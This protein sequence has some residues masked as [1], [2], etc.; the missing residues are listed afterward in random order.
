VGRRSFAGY[1]C[2]ESLSIGLFGECFRAK[3]KK[4]TEARVV[5]VDS[6]L[7]KRKRFASALARHGTKLSEL[8]HPHVVTTQTVGRGNDGSLVVIASPVA[9]P[10]ELGAL[11]ERAGGRIPRDI[12]LS[13]AMGA[14]RGLSHAHEHEVTHGGVHP[15]SIVV[16]GKGVSKLSD[17]GLARALASAAAA[18]EDSELLRGLRGYVAPELALG[19]EPDAASDVFAAG[20]L[21]SQLLW[22]QPTPPDPE[23]SPL[24]DV[25]RRAINTDRDK[26]FSSASEL[27]GALRRAISD[28]NLEVAVASKVGAYTQKV[29]LGREDTGLLDAETEDLLN[30]LGL[31]AGQPAGPRQSTALEEV[32]AG[33]GEFEGLEDED[34][35][36][37]LTRPVPPTAQPVAPR[38]IAPRAATPAPVAP[39][40]ATPAPVAPRAAAPRPVAPRAATPRPVAPRPVA[41]RPI[42][43]RVAGTEDITNVADPDDITDVAD[44]DDITNV[45]D[46]EDIISVASPEDVIPRAATPRPV[47][48][49]PH[50]SPGELL[51]AQDPKDDYDDDDDACTAVQTP[52]PVEAVDPVEAL[53]QANTPK[54]SAIDPFE[55]ARSQRLMTPS[56]YDVADDTPLPVPRPFHVDG[57]HAMDL[58]E[59]V[60]EQAATSSPFDDVED[61]PIEKVKRNNTLRLL[62]LIAFV[63]AALVAVAYTK[64]DFFEAAKKESSARKAE[65]MAKAEKLQPIPGE[66]T[67]ISKTEDAAVWLLLGRTPMTSFVL[68]SSMIHELRI[69]H[70][71]FRP[72]FLSVAAQHWTGEANYRIA[73]L[74]ATLVQE[75]SPTVLPA[76]PPIADPPLTPGGNGQGSL[77]VKSTPAG[78]EVWML[79]GS[80]PIMNL[81]GIE[82]GKDYAF[83]VLKE[84]HRPATASFKAKDWYLTGTSGPVKPG[85][86]KQLELEPLPKAGEE[87][88]PAPEGDKAEDDK[89]SKRRK[90]KRRRGK[91]R[92]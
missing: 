31:E 3:N 67:V 69:E 81:V 70:E 33:M 92:K 89:K 40:A 64:T 20:A 32:L 5:V 15:R 2:E 88:A 42:S 34:S 65:A 23:Q 90:K 86:V 59:L 84:G 38:P 37:E 78:A 66:L 51:D 35:S 87:S 29:Q 55:R 71:G 57:T 75:E 60:G 49:R 16:D 39:R 9:A 53:I 26:R 73:N 36:P 50:S 61:L 85:L 48:P 44:P 91:K 79:V 1:A 82:A 7:A 6:R 19:Q 46:P 41:P 17:F 76:F 11:L 52:P 58:V 43:S 28:G 56:D 12:A 25:L 10:I 18:A 4:G 77:E 27:E 8:V 22:E 24:A 72:I 63:F 68:P 30:S 74:S 13:I 62:A 14:M 83:K 21:V 80:T 54:P 45:A 47:F